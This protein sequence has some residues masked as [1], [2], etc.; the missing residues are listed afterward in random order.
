MSDLK[1][2]LMSLNSSRKLLTGDLDAI[3]SYPYRPCKP[4]VD[5]IPDGSPALPQAEPEEMGL[6]SSHIESFF[7]ALE[8]HGYRPHS[9]M[10]LRRGKVLAEGYWAPYR[11]D[12]PQSVYSL[13]KSVLSMAVGIAAGEGRLSLEDPLDK[14]FPE[15]PHSLGADLFRPLVLGDLLT[16]RSGVDFNES[17]VF[18]YEDWV[19]A[20]LSAGRSFEPGSQF[21]YNSLNSYMLAAVLRQVTGQTLMEYL[22]PRLF[23]PLGIRNA[24]WETCPKGIEKGGWGLHLTTR[25]MAALG[26]LMLQ[27]GAWTGPDGE[28][29]QLIPEVWVRE[30]TRSRTKTRPDDGGR[31]YGYHNWIVSSEGDYEFNGAFGQLVVVL[32]RHEVVVAL[33]AGSTCSFVT[34]SASD[35]ILAYFGSDACYAQLPRNT[36]ALR[37]LHRTLRSLKVLQ[38]TPPVPA[39][40][41]PTEP[42]DKKHTAMPAVPPEAMRYH[43][44]TMPMKKN[45]AG[46]VPFVQQITHNNF[47]PGITGIRF[48]LGVDSC[49]LTFIG[50]GEKNRLTVGTDGRPRHSVIIAGGEHYHVYAT[51]T[52]SYR[53]PQRPLLHLTLTFPELPNTRLVDILFHPDTVSLRF[54]ERPGRSDCLSILSGLMNAKALDKV[55]VDLTLKNH[56][57]LSAFAR[58]A[59]P[60][61]YSERKPSQP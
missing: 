21:L 36:A 56:Q 19:S 11:A 30:A 44:V 10:V 31:G 49:T 23:E 1:L 28:N 4:L 24:W 51:G 34:G 5:P 13:S 47:S 57:F 43:N 16:M 33:T 38:I 41:L 54:D 27:N 7:R 46:L 17:C 20:Y 52:W 8:L 48:S 61:I 42:P 40:K 32:P 22:T 29:R 45:R 12:I 37:S 58:V 14:F 3:C 9:A 26:Q 39:R 53:R 50:P 59:T 60:V 15:H 2:K 25:D 6:S 55:V 35:L 18:L